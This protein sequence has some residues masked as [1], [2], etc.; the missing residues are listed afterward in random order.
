MSERAPGNPDYFRTHR[1][2]ALSAA[3]IRSMAKVTPEQVELVRKA[4]MKAKSLRPRKVKTA[5][6]ANKV[7]SRPR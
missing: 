1:G 3:E 5:T 2:P 6:S 4:M 7:T